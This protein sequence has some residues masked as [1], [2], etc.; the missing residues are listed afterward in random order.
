MLIPLGSKGH[1]MSLSMNSEANYSNNKLKFVKV[2]P[3]LKNG[4]V[5]KDT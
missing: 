3:E 5:H 1:L 2:G 4:S